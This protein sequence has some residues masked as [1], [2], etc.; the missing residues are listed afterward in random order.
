MITRTTCKKAREIINKKLIEAANELGVVFDTMG[1][2]SYSNT[3]FSFKAKFFSSDIDKNSK[4]ES[5]L[6]LHG[7]KLG[8]AEIRWNKEKC[9]IVDVTPRGNVI[10]EMKGNKYKVKPNQLKQEVICI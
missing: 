3:E 9:I 4:I 7:L 6:K 1:S 5:N 8:S 2:M 10:V